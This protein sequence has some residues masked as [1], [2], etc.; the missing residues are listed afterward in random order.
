MLR[1]TDN[2]TGDEGNDANK[3][4]LVDRIFLNESLPPT[5]LP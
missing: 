2:E 5:N 1:R 4:I 3:K